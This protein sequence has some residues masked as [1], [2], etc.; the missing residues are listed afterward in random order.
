M[1]TAPAMTLAPNVALRG[2]LAN[3]FSEGDTPA[4]NPDIYGSIEFALCGYGS[5]VP[6]VAGQAIFSGATTPQ[7]A[8]QTGADDGGEAGDF[9]VWLYS[10][11]LI[12]PA[13][14]YYTVTIRNSNG[15]VLQVNAYLL[16]GGG[17][18]D[19]STLQPYDPN[20][21]PP[22]LPPLIINQLL[23]VPWASDVQFPGDEYLTYRL[24][25]TDDVTSS[26]IT[27]PQPGNLYTFI[28]AQDSTGNHLFAWP[29]ICVNPPQIYPPPNGVTIQTF[30]MGGV[31]LWPIGAPTWESL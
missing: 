27:N 20:Q 29:S 14:T 28:I 4:P 24:M 3:I 13:G 15:D 16:I 25:L 22:R 2:T 19:L 6:R 7:I 31:Y 9:L 23:I 11:D 18:F 1:A 21:P 17:S 12:D 10:N 5:Q 26:E 8:M 30:V